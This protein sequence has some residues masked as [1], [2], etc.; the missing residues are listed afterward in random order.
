MSRS[1]SVLTIFLEMVLEYHC[2]MCSDSQQLIVMSGSEGAYVDQLHE[3]FR[4][5]N[6]Q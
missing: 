5:S 6:S 2:K 4:V 3:T 1:I